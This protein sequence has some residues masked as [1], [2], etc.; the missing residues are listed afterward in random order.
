M[1]VHLRMRFPDGRWL[2]A[3]VRMLAALR[4]NPHAGSDRTT[5][6]SV[7]LEP[8]P[9]TS[10]ARIK[11]EVDFERLEPIGCACWLYRVGPRSKRASSNWR[12]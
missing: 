10:E 12:R 9:K 3:E 6:I 8:T 7:E 11:G 5:R 4:R 2:G 1:R